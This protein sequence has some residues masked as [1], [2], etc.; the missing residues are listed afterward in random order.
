MLGAP[1]LQRLIVG[2]NS[3]LPN[4]SQTICKDFSP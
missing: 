2:G 3:N 1:L 4:H